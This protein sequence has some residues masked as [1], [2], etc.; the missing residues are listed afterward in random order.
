[1]YVNTF[2]SPA[3]D[4]PAGIL[5]ACDCIN[6]VLSAELQKFGLSSSAFQLLTLLEVGEGLPVGELRA[7]LAISPAH[8]AG[9][10]TGLRKRGLLERAIARE[11]RAS[12]LP[13]GRKLLQQVNE[14][15]T[16]RMRELTSS[17]TTQE[18]T[19]LCQLLEKVRLL[20]LQR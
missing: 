16:R 2:I 3:E 10:L 19:T 12:L 11:R 9:L 6:G 14:S 8:L 15:Q 20:T 18:R 4:V 13:A 17:F 7:L 1:M 5:E